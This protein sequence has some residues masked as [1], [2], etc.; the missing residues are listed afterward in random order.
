MAVPRRS[1]SWRDVVG[2][3]TGGH[4]LSHF[5]LLSFPPLFP[6]LAEAFSLSNVELG[7]VFSAVSLTTVLQIPVGGVVDRVGAKRVFVLGVAVTAIGMALVGL[8]PSYPALLAFALVSGVGQSAFHPADY[9]LL[10][11]VAGGHGEGRSFGIHTFGGYVGYAAAPLVV[12]TVAEI[13]DW[14]V[15]LVVVGAVGVVYA[16]G[17]HFA[18]DDVY[19]AR[20]A[21][22]GE[23][24]DGAN[25]DAADGGMLAALLRLPML[26]VFVLF[27][28][29]TMATTGV[30]TFTPILVIED[31]GGST[32]IGNAALTGYFVL[33]AGGVLVGG[34]LADRF[35]PARLIAVVVGGSAL[36]TWASVS[37]VLE[38]PFAIGTL[39]LVGLFNGLALPSRDR[40]V[41]AVSSSGSVGASFGLVFAAASIAQVISPAALG[42]VI[43]AVSASAAFLVAGGLF[44]ATALIAL[45]CGA[46]AA[47]SA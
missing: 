4:F 28:V 16:V 33:A 20:L 2:V 30:Q 5:Y 43:D 36:A 24:G 25:D 38:L 45:A 47:R 3:V 41:S 23:S 9:A 12:G 15:A 40:L 31:F 44:A 29:L 17:A 13:Y 34:L 42:A 10:D 37:G 11:A 46:A 35:A 1:D 27:V 32:A 22:D 14:R 8:A 39:A 26:S 6:A 18:I 7:L 21:A 19:R